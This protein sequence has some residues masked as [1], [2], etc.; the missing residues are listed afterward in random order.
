[1]SPHAKTLSWTNLY[2]GVTPVLFDADESRPVYEVCREALEVLKDKGLLKSG[3]MVLLT[4][5]D[6]METVGS[7]NTC[8]VMMVE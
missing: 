1:M 3:D 7:T 8:K 5:G 2:R 4:H 6:K